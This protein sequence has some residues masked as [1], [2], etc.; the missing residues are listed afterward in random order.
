MTEQEKI[1]SETQ[2]KLAVQDAKFE[3]FMRAQDERFNS[4]MRELQR[5]R[6]EIR[7]QNEKHDADMKEIR[8]EIRDALKNLQ[9][10]TIAAVVG[11]AAISVGVLGFLWTTAR[12]MESPPPNQPAQTT[13][14]QTTG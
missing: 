4:F 10:L 12:S 9:G 11:I 6:E 1:N 5:Q 2:M 7:Q 14:Y 13:Q 3:V 8:G